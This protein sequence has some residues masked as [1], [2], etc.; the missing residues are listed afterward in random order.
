MSERKGGGARCRAGDDDTA[1]GAGR[2]RSQ[3]GPQVGRRHGTRQAECEALTHMQA[4]SL[5][6]SGDSLRF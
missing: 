4:L 5:H 3:W 1:K 2:M 6:N